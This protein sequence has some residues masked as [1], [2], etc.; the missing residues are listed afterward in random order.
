MFENGKSTKQKKNMKK[1][2]NKNIFYS[3]SRIE[4]HQKRGQKEESNK[5]KT[6]I[7]IL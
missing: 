2:Y 3:F 7:F 6:F 1:L 4:N 5:I